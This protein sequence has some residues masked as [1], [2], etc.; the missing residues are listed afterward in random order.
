MKFVSLEIKGVREEDDECMVVE[1]DADA[2]F[3][4]IYGRCEKG[5][6]YCIGDFNSRDAANIIMGALKGA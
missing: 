1:D 4:S 6:A 2:M 3:F 5:L